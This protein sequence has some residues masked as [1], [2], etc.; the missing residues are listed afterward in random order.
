[1]AD[2]FSVNATRIDTNVK[3]VLYGAAAKTFSLRGTGGGTLTVTVGEANEFQNQWVLPSY[4]SALA[5][6]YGPT[7]YP[8]K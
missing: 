5:N 6:P 7:I 4:W 2:L 1:M 8:G 3:F